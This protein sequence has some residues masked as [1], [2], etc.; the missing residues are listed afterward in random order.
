MA[1]NIVSMSALELGK[2]T[3]AK[4]AELFHRAVVEAI[5]QSI[6]HG[7]VT[8]ATPLLRMLP[9]ISKKS[10]ARDAL[11]SYFEKWGNLRYDREK[12]AF[13]HSK[14]HKP[15]DWCAEFERSL[16][17][18]TW[19]LGIGAAPRAPAKAKPGIIDADKEFRSVLERLRR[20]SEDADKVV[21][22]SQLLGKVQEVL[23]AY[24]RSDAFDVEEKRGRA[25]F[26]RST[27]NSTIRASKF[28]K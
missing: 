23:L 12:D 2:L 17:D 19:N 7:N 4:R 22:H 18:Q 16:I 13:R 10:D 6:E 21:L 28:A 9:V 15:E 11:I 26:D 1:K 8:V 3:P 27:A 20:I 14:Q 5:Q 24:G 25:L